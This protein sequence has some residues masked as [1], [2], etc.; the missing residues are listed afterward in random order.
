MAKSLPLGIDRVHTPTR[1]KALFY[2]FLPVHL[3]LVLLAWKI[4]RYL[5]DLNQFANREP[6]SLALIP[7]QLTHPAAALIM[8]R[9]LVIYLYQFVLIAINLLAL[10]HHIEEPPI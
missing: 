2:E 5:E 6:S 9:L 10:L 4:L 7:L 8:Y 3:V 1:K